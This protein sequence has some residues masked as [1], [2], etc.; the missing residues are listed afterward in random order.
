MTVDTAVHT[1]CCQQGCHMLTTATPQ[2]QAQARYREALAAGWGIPAGARLLEIACGQGDMSA[3]LAHAVGATGHV[4]GVDIASPGYGAPLTLGE[5]TAFLQAGP[6]GE[7]L[8]FR[9]ETD[10]L[11]DAILYPDDAFDAVVLAHGAWYF[12]SQEQL[13]ATLRRVRQWA[14]RLHIAEWDLEPQTMEQIPHLL[15][16][17]LQGLIEGYHPDSE[18]NV[19]TPFSREQMLALLAETGWQV[20]HEF[21]ADTSALQDGAWEVDLALH[22][23]LP[24]VDAL[25][26][27]GHVRDQLR[28]QG[29]LLRALASRLSPRALPAYALT[30][31]RLSLS[32]IA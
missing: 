12:A 8:T 1:E 16:V 11:D 7:R 32:E 27:P 15:A 19:R 29:D 31:A 30:A 14:P 24:T 9:F 5:A 23:A 3:V 13:R 6:L 20:T 28:S 21:R 4:T 17:L 22:D 25:L 26:V 2:D 18:A 10:L